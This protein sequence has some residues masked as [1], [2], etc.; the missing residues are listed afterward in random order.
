M[1]KNLFTLNPL[2]FRMVVFCVNCLV[3]NILYSTTNHPA[4]KLKSSKS[5]LIYIIS[6]LLIIRTKA[7]FEK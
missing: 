3:Y 5:V 2:C 1:Y 6:V 4:L 7:S